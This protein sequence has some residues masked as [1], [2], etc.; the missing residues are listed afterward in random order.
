LE[1]EEYRCERSEENIRFINYRPDLFIKIT[2]EITSE[3]RIKLN[4]NSYCEIQFDQLNSIYDPKPF[5]INLSVAGK[6]YSRM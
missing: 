1:K 3:Q 6:E 5:I 4:N 2:S